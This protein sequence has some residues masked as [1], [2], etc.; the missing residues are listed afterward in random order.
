[1]P[2]L[3]VA[4]AASIAEPR[5]DLATAAGRHWPPVAIG[6]QSAGIAQSVECA[7]TCRLRQ[8]CAGDDVER[9]LLGA[10]DPISSVP[11]VHA[12]SGCFSP[13]RPT[14]PGP[15]VN[16]PDTIKR[17]IVDA[18]GTRVFVRT[19]GRADLLECLSRR[20]D[21]ASAVAELVDLAVAALQRLG[22]ELR[23]GELQD[24][25]LRFGDGVVV[26]GR[27]T[28]EQNLAVVA[29]SECNVGLLINH[30][31]RL[32]SHTGQGGAPSR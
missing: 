5:Y 19:N 18:H 7:E 16:D 26:L 1:M 12:D 29:D 14:A 9:F 2:P 8:R 11:S 17:S 15:L 31:R 27:G 6:G 23:V 25:V 10:A 20:D 4:P 32:M 13:S 30:V 21:S 28:P 3:D 22:E 24:V